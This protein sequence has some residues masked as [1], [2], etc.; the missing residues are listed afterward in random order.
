MPYELS[1]KAALQEFWIKVQEKYADRKFRHRPPTAL[2]SDEDWERQLHSFLGAN[3]PCPATSDFRVVWER[4]LLEMEQLGIRA[5]PETF[6]TYNDGDA[7]F[8]R[9][10]WCLIHHLRPERVIETGVAHGLSSRMILEALQRNARGHL[11]SIDLPPSDS[12]L[13]KRIGIA[14]QPPFTERWTYVAGSSRRCLR[15]LLNETGPI[16]LFL[17][18]SLHSERNVRFELEEARNALRP[19][20]AIVVDD[21]DVNGA[22]QHFRNTA[23]DFQSLICEAEPVRPDTRRFNQ[24]G[25]FGIFVRSPGAASTAYA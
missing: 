16:D 5:G 11:W 3:W 20:G 21:V 22:F 2:R 24:K 6:Q 4:V 17:H 7:G 23:T 13:R 1:G 18:D 14:V 10:A 19:R 12:S 9:A 8:L 25:L 15:P